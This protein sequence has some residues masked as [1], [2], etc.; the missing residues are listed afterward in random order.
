LRGFS[1]KEVW[2]KTSDLQSPLLSF[3]FEVLGSG[4]LGEKLGIPGSLLPGSRED[5]S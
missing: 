5:Y 3:G 4:S 2:L 1:L